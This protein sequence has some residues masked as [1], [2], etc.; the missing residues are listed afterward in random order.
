MVDIKLTADNLRM[1]EAA[2]TDDERR[3]CIE[4][5]LERARQAKSARSF[6]GKGARGKST[7]LSVWKSVRDVM[8]E[9][10]GDNL[11]VPPYPDGTW[12][13]KVYYAVTNAGM[14]EEYLKRLATHAKEHMRSPIEMQFLV[15]MHER[16][17]QGEWDINKGGTAPPSMRE[18]WAQNQKMPED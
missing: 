5:I 11:K 18:I 13:R 9:V 15:C 4:L 10:L 6:G 14:D 7:D 1:L 2:S 3:G 12:I 17:L 8:K 16:V